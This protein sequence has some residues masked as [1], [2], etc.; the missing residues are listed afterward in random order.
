[1]DPLYIVLGGLVIVGLIVVLALS[2]RK[3]KK[4]LD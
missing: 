3:L 4:L 2:V 1:M